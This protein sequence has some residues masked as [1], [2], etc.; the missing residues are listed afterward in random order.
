LSATA[1]AA[2]PPWGRGAETLRR[3]NGTGGVERDDFHI[4]KYKLAL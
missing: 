3:E 2:A 4:A 1:A